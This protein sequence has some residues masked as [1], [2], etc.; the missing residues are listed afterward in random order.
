[1]KRGSWVDERQTTGARRYYCV[2][3]ADKHEIIKPEPPA[4]FAFGRRINRIA[5]LL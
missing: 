5:G 4:V 2:P 1:M 3:C